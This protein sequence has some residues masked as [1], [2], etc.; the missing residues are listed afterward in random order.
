MGKVR[1]FCPAPIENQGQTPQLDSDFPSNLASGSVA[2]IEQGFQDRMM[3][4]IK[5]KYGNDT[6]KFRLSLSSSLVELQQEVVKRLNM[7]AG[8]YCVKYRDEEDELILI[9]LRRGLTRLYTHF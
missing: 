2:N 3:V 9:A 6:I 5:A 4:S 8:T 7:E 1:L